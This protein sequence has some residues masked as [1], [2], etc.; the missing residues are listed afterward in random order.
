MRFERLDLLRYGGFQETTLNFPK[1]ARDLHVIYG[2]N[3]AGKST[4]LC[5]IRDFLFGFPHHIAGDW[6]T[7]ASLLR[8]G[9]S[10]EQDG[11]VFEGVRRRGRTQ[12]LFAADDRTP[13]EDLPLRT[14]LGGLD[15]KGFE[16][17]W[18]LDH[19]RL[20][21]GGEEMRRLK[22]DAGLQILAAGLG[23][24]GVG[25]LSARLQ[26]D[27]GSEWK[28]GR[29]RSAL[30]QAR[31]KLTALQTALRSDAVTVKKLSVANKELSES[32]AE[33]R[34]CDA[35]AQELGVRR[36]TNS[37]L[38]MTSVPFQK[39][40]QTET[41]MVSFPDW[42]LT[43][44]DCDR[45]ENIIESLQ[46][47]E[48]N[49]SVLR[50]RF[51]ALCEKIQA[52]GDT[53]P[54][55]AE[56]DAIQALLKRSDL[57][58]LLETKV[59]E[60][61]IRLT[62]DAISLEQFW[63]RHGC[64]AGA[65]P[66]REELDDLGQR[67]QARALLRTQEQDLRARLQETEQALNILHPQ[68][69]SETNEKIRPENLRR[70]R[71]ELDEARSLGALD[72]RIDSLAAEVLR[73]GDATAAA[74]GALMPW[75]ANTADRKGEL[76][77]LAL[78]DGTALEDE[79]RLWATLDEQRRVA[80][81]ETQA[82][83]TE[84]ARL[85]QQCRRLEE[86]GQAVSW[87]QLSAARQERD[88]LWQ[89]ME[90]Q[91]HS[92]GCPAPATREAFGVLIQNADSLADRRHAH[93]EQS[94]Q[95]ATLL[96]QGEDLALRA[97]EA[98]RRGMRAQDELDRRQTAWTALLESF[99][100]PVLPP[101]S[102]QAWMVR[103][104]ESLTAEE[105]LQSA[106]KQLQAATDSRGAMSRRLQVFGAESASERLAVQIRQATSLLEQREDEA[107]EADA[108]KKDRLQREEALVKDRAALSSVEQKLAL[109]EE[110]WARACRNC[111]YPGRAE[112]ADLR[113][114][115]EALTIQTRLESEQKEQDTEARDIAAFRTELGGFLQRYGQGS[116]AELE[117]FLT[118]ELE[119]ERERKSV[120]QQHAALTNEI[121]QADLR[122]VELEQGLDPARRLL[123]LGA[124]DDLRHALSRAR[125]RA[126]LCDRR[127][128]LREQILQAGNGRSLE[129]LLDEAR[130][131]DPEQLERD[132]EEI[133]AETIA[134][135]AR[136]SAVTERLLQAR[137][138]LAELESARGVREV[139]E[140]IQETEAEIAERASRY[141]S[142]R[143]QQ[144][145]LSRLVEQG[146]QQAHGPLLSRAGAL[147]S[148]LTLGRYEGLVTEESGSDGLVLAGQRMASTTPV[149]VHAMSEGTRD[150]LYLALRLASVEQALE[151]GIRLPF[152]ADDLFV[153]FD[154][155]RTDVGLQI[156][157]EFSEKTQV[158]FFTHHGYITNKSKEI[159]YIIKL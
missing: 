3:E 88:R 58:A 26:E 29:A 35:A 107:R 59:E 145:M 53:S 63:A 1:G 46:F 149:P 157:A 67:L 90:D 128:E 122:I 17:A 49:A 109:W 93:A 23:L 4:T 155:E 78:P 118:L 68:S 156:L 66:N 48:H 37:R 13:L 159:P 34:S 54:V 87:E 19:T 80:R 60:R 12:T 113:D 103:R 108:R 140:D 64:E 89:S 61:K 18:A 20:R 153:T 158:L 44:E 62:R 11:T 154:E 123:G 100:A 152:L 96:R 73:L 22:D 74:Y 114:V 105:A 25:K 129:S 41:E 84:G 119:R 28:S 71:L 15:S 136:R 125:E 99:G 131:T 86:D 115:A 147:F 117:R 97:E 121:A 91:F 8:V 120:M 130:M 98:G 42:N 45:F 10:L 50:Q 146:R 144:L 95:L 57:V 27:V 150:Q 52:F 143:L 135:D 116:A 65:L 106:K 72:D 112:Q 81:D 142:L 70:F 111:R 7:A 92:G 30:Q 9:A 31:L 104:Q 124:E 39:L 138:V 126:G 6:M 24:E 51:E 133:E 102:L 94:A 14:W 82:A 16:A 55:F 36:R 137:S 43:I 75:R 38:K 151:R 40:M 101:A 77:A 110:D 32:E 56:Q 76:T 85:A 132:F 134:L 83:E 79:A 21:E 47:E 33:N 69:V 141:V 148:R 139:A 2:A 127:D 5:A